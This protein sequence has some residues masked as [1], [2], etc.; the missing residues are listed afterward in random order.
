MLGSEEKAED[1]WNSKAKEIKDVWSFITCLA[2]TQHSWKSGVFFFN[3]A[4][5]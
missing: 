2:Q 1:S 4:S 5:S 3:A